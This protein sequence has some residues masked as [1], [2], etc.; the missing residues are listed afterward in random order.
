MCCRSV[1]RKSPTNYILLLI[2]TLSWVYTIGF[3]CAMYSAE[4]VMTASLMTMVITVALTSYAFFT[5]SDFTSLCGPF[6]CFGFIIICT[7][8][9]I[10]SLVSWIVFSYTE[11]WYPFAS[12]AFV[13]IYGI[14]LLIDTQLVVGGGRYELSIDDYIIGAMIL[15]L[16]I[17]MIF[18]ELLKIFGRR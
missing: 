11:T 8:A 4:V 17:I 12:G 16:D 15:Y 7:V 13:I 9:M 14:F 1:A 10:M 3:I 5:K 2:F 6:F 18:L